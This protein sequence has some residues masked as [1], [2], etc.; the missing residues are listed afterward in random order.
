MEQIVIDVDDLSRSIGLKAPATG[1][2]AIFLLSAFNAVLSYGDNLVWVPEF[3]QPKRGAFK[4]EA[5][6]DIEPPDKALIKEFVSNRIG[7]IATERECKDLCPRAF[8]LKREAR[9]SEFDTR[10]KQV[11]EAWRNR[12]KRPEA[13]KFSPSVQRVIRGAMKEADYTD[14]VALIEYAYEADEGPARFWRGENKDKRTYLGLD[15]LLRTQK[16]QGR[17]QLVLAWKSKTNSKSRMDEVDLGP[18]A[19]RGV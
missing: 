10:V 6:F 3:H 7:R 1:D 4:V 2:S 14:L 16:L 18:F 17:L 19:R 5:N 13:C 11:W 15:N 12:Q 9:C 8:G